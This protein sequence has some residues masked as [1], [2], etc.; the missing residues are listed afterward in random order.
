MDT[1]KAGYQPN[2]TSGRSTRSIDEEEKSI[3]GRLLG[4][5]FR[6]HGTLEQCCFHNGERLFGGGRL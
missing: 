1:R 6:D 5:E 4:L 3:E 2:M